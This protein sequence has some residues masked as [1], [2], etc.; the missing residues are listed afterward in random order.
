M[1]LFSSVSLIFLIYF[2]QILFF[3]SA[4]V[5]DYERLSRY[6]YQLFLM[7]SAF[8]FPKLVVNVGYNID[9]FMQESIWSKLRMLELSVYPWQFL[10]FEGNICHQ[11]VKC[12][13]IM[14]IV[15][16]VMN[17]LSNCSSISSGY[18]S[19]YY[20]GFFLVNE[21]CFTVFIFIWL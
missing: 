3:Y 18:F 13:F 8:S 17:F 16:S 7:Y 19:Q 10:F 15:P 9:S 21:E 4:C 6:L 11:I 14:K 12:F 20:S 1:L 5:P 2:F